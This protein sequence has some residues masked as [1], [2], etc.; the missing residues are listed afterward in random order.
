MIRICF[1]GLLCPKRGAL[2]QA[3]MEI[4]AASA[5]AAEQQLNEAKEE[6]QASAAPWLSM[7]AFVYGGLLV[8]SSEPVEIARWDG[9]EKGCGPIHCV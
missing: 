1:K 5:A 3:K 9:T 8:E 2:G 7:C 4:L 6:G